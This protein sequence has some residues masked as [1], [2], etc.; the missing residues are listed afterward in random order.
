MLEKVGGRDSLPMLKA[1][2]A[3]ADAELLV[4]IESAEKSI[5]Q[6]LGQ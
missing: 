6:R 3:G 1:A 4:R 2:R 5:N